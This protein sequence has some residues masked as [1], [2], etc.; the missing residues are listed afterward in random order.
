MTGL[1]HIFNLQCSETVISDTSHMVR[2]KEMG[3]DWDPECLDWNVDYS[4]RL[5][6]QGHDRVRKTVCGFCPDSIYR[7]FLCTY[8][9]GWCLP[10]VL[11]FFQPYYQV[12]CQDDRIGPGLERH[13]FYEG[14]KVPGEYGMYKI[15]VF[16]THLS[17]VSCLGYMCNTFVWLISYVHK[18]FTL[19]W[20][21]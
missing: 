20:A 2:S 19:M 17:L 12:Q 8:Q 16:L 13:L 18:T 21:T 1:G 11:D 14:S 10:G 15:K 3:S 4:N 7:C 6:D 9:P 5:L